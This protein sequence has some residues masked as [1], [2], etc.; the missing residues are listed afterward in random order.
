MLQLLIIEDDPGLQEQMR[1]CID[2]ATVHVASSAS[3]AL[4]VL[5]EVDPQVVTLDLGLPPDPGGVSEG[6]QLLDTIS[7]S[8]PATKVIVVTGHEDHD[9]AL[10]AINAGAHDYYTKPIDVQTLQFAVSRAFHLWQ[11]EQELAH[12]RRSKIEQATQRIPGL[13]T[14]ADNMLQVCSLIERVAPTD[15]S[16][17][18]LGQTG[19]GKEVVAKAIHAL[20]NRA[21]GPFVAINCSAIPENLLESELFGFEKG[22]FTGAQNRKVGKIETAHGGTLL[23]DEIGDMNLLLQSK[24]LRFLQERQLE[25]LGSNETIGVDVRVLSATHQSLE[26]LVA[27]QAF[28]SDLYYR[29]SEIELVLPALNERVGDAVL[30]ARYFL[31]RLN[32][33]RPLRLHPSAVRALED[34]AWPG[35]VRE[36]ENRVNRAAIMADNNEITAQDLDLSVPAGTADLNLKANRSAVEITLIQAALSRTEHNMSEAA[37]LLGVSRPTLYNLVTKYEIDS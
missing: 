6:L 35:N 24:I 32:S 14:T 2:D 34:Y 7:K 12:L 9:N 16:V 25:R 31:Q 26:E 10:R 17:L 18:I 37:R 30:L 36:L 5:K 3:E 13:V 33:E 8:Y 20:S 19:T 4:A 27:A 28:R 1:W 23:L 29:I 21:D 15:A 11:L 22:A